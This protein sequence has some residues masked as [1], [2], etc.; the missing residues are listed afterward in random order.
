MK[1]KK[2]RNLLNNTYFVI[3]KERNQL[4]RCVLSYQ[5]LVGTRL[6]N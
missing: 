6:K 1:E 3:F 4:T 5:F 2:L